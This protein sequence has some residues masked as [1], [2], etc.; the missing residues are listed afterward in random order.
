MNNTFIPS[1]YKANPARAAH[2]RALLLAALMGVQLSLPWQAAWATPPIEPTKIADQPLSTL[3]GI[4]ANVLLA[5]SVEFPTAV[6]KAHGGG[7][8]YTPTKKYRGYFDERKCYVYDTA[9]QYFRPAAW[10][11]GPNASTCSGQWSGNFMNWATMQSID[12]FRMAMSGGYRAIDTNTETV[13]EKALSSN[14]AD[15]AFFPIAEILNNPSTV[16]ASTPFN[17][18]RVRVRVKALGS[19]IW[20]TTNPPATDDPF[21]GDPGSLTGGTPP[22]G[23]TKMR[24]RVKVCDTSLLEANCLRYPS[25]AYKPV[26]LLQENATK[27]RF[28]AFGYLAEAS[29]DPQRDGGVLRA[30]LKTLAPALPLVDGAGGANPNRE[31]DPD[32]G[33]FVVNPNPADASASSVPNSGVINYLNKFGLAAQ[34]YKAFDPVAEMYW[35]ALRYL[36][37]RP[38]ARAAYVAGMTPAMKDG[39]PVLQTWAD[40][41]QFQCQKNFILGIGDV[42]THRD[43]NLPGSSHL[44]NEGNPAVTDDSGLN[45]NVDEELE[46]IRV[47]EG[48]PFNAVFANAMGSGGH[49]NFS[50]GSPYVAALASFA[51]HVDQ[52]PGPGW[53]GDQTVSTF[54]VDVHEKGQYKH[55]NQYWYAAKY[56]G[57]KE[58]DLTPGPNLDSEWRSKGRTFTDANGTF[59]LPDNYFLASDPDNLIKSLGDA[60]RDINERLSS[61]SGLGLST[62]NISESGEAA[63]GVSYD[64]SNWSGRLSAFSLQVA[65]DGTVVPTFRWEARTL[66]DQRMATGGVN[67]RV[68]ATAKPAVGSGVVGIPFQLNALSSAQQQALGANAATRTKVLEFLRGIR[69]NEGNSGGLRVRGSVLGDIVASEAVVVDKSTARYSESLNR[70]YASFVSSNQTRP[71]TVYVGANDGMLHA[72]DGSLTGAG[73]GRERW[74]YVPS[75]LFAGPHGEPADSGLQA[76]ARPDY[77]HRAF[78]DATPVVRDVDF[79]RTVGASTPAPADSD[80]RTILVGGLGKGGRG[81]YALDVTRPETLTTEAQLAGKVLWEFTDDDMG[82]S[83]G[84]P[85]IFKTAQHGWVVALTSGYNNIHGTQA[86]QGFIYLLNARTGALIQKIGTGSGTAVSPSG[87]AHAVAYIPALADYTADSIYAGDLLGN[88]WRF[89]LRAASGNFPAPTL[90]TQL[91]STTGNEPQPVTTEPEVSADPATQVRYVFVGTGRSLHPD[92]RITV[93]QTFYSI[94]DGTRDTMGPAPSAPI[95]KPDLAQLTSLTDGV[96]VPPNGRGWYHDL[97]TTIDNFNARVD[98]SPAA[99]GGTVAFATNTPSRNPCAPMT[100][101]VYV[102]TYGSGKSVLQRI[103]GNGTTVPLQWVTVPQAVT[104]LQRI[105]SSQRGRT[106]ISTSDVPLATNEGGALGGVRRLNWREVTTR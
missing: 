13:L 49:L 5:L 103:Q 53:P 40:P 22:A 76:L 60:F 90:L 79:S 29:S 69:T 71:A 56:G 84:K 31:W 82:Y 23:A 102:V 61:S 64:S 55:K 100:G 105:S 6:V 36:Q 86:G 83:V 95:G 34:T 78:V 57:F 80:W 96:I 66:L 62:P 25:G 3:S 47:A 11:T 92:D 32:T 19:Y 18:S 88:L 24:L 73:A 27:M 85:R 26:G 30:P 45:L 52:R 9:S 43:K 87:L 17:T 39:F 58:Q 42:F 20:V 99:N 44:D 91:R 41:V 35:E 54:W 14:Q 7:T 46:K 77:A 51:R 104:K 2:P 4:P 12:V 74:A 93:P 101:T 38:A 8:N 50:N 33:I 67:A 21:K 68:I 75:S 106:L 37:G 48:Q 98:V 28:G 97:P 63:Y 72:F 16:Q 65:A 94:V 15:D 81:Y 89:D 1:H 10:A 59:D 70:G